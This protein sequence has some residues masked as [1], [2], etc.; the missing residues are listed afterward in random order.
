MGGD[1]FPADGFFF[2]E[3]I[4]QSFGRPRF[5]GCNYAVRIN[6]K[7]TRGMW[8]PNRPNPEGWVDVEA[9][10]RSNELF[11]NLRLC[12]NRVDCVGCSVDD[13][14]LDKFIEEKIEDEL[15]DMLVTNC[16]GLDDLMD[17]RS[18]LLENEDDYAAV[19]GSL[20]GTNPDK[21]SLRHH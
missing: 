12:L 10:V 7:L 11:P 5:N 6:F 8:A 4:L 9:T 15:H 3:L 1:S 18:L 16:M 21:K 13:T 2:D 14:I 17:R 19:L 20:Y